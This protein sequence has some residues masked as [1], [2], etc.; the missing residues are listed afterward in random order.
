[1]NIQDATIGLEVVRAKGDYV[2]G[3]VGNI[4]AIDTEK[5]RAQ[6]NWGSWVSFNVIEPTSIP[7]EIIPATTGRDRFGYPKH[8]HPKY[9]KL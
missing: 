3:R 5:N 9:K 1:M 2:V 4:I 6:V 7:Y 8:T